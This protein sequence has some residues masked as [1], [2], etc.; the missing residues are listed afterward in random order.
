MS[1]MTLWTREEAMDWLRIGHSTFNRYK[2]QGLIP[3]V[4]IGGKPLIVKE[5]LEKRIKRQLNNA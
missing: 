3:I 1:E 4:K 2:N 5:E